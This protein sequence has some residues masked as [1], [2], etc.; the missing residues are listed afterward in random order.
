MK[1]GRHTEILLILGMLFALVAS[2]LPVLYTV[3]YHEFTNIPQAKGGSI[4]LSD[5]SGND[6]IVLDGEWEFYWN[7]FLVTNPQE[8]A[9]PDFL[10]HVPDYWSK[11]KIHGDYLPADGFASYR[12]LLKGGSSAPVTIYLP[13]FGS[14]YRVFIDGILTAQS[15]NV[16]ED[17]AEVFTTTKA[18]L[19]P[20][21]LTTQQK[22]EVIIEV[23]TT[24]F[25]GLY[26]A[27]VM[28]DYNQAVHS[29]TIR[30]DLR[31]LLFG[32]ALFSFF[33]LI[34]GYILSYSTEKHSVWLS[35]I[36]LCVLLRIMLTT[37][38]F[39]FWQDK[40]FFNLS[41]EATNPLMF[42]LS[43]AFKYL[44]I[45]L[46]EELLGIDFSKKEKM[47]LLHYYTVF[48]LV[49]LI[50]P[51]GF[52]NRYLTILLPVC[53]FLI[54]IY[55]FF[56]IYRNRHQLKQYG[57]LVY[58][59]ATLAITGLIIDCYYINGNIY[60]N[61]SMALLLLF[62]AYLII[63]GLVSSIQ[64]S[65]I[66]RDLAMSS[67]SIASARAQIAMQTEYYNALSAQMHEIRAVRH[68]FHHFVNVLKR[69]CDEAKYPELKC[70]LSE[71]A[72]KADT[73]PLP[74]FCENVV[75]NSI[76]GYYSLRL[77]EH[78]IPFHCMCHIPKELSV[79]DSDLCI[80]LGN[81]LENAME[82]C[83]KVAASDARSVLAEARMIGGQLLIKITNTYN[84]TVIAVGDTFLTTKAEP[85]HGIGMKN[86]KKVLDSY[87]GY[88]KLENNQ[89]EFTLMA[90][91]PESRSAAASS[92]DICSPV[93]SI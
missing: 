55:A 30:N 68:D 91:F 43:F 90:A 59:G 23:A 62:T 19:Y 72:G 52:Y 10:I 57:L 71:Y 78:D 76:L 9:A 80:V 39:G 12:L 3:F 83:K 42:F 41:Y 15:G 58:G 14:A 34:V 6:R 44:L 26:M 21:T 85:F 28:M 74:V 35:V 70:F 87:G 40:V 64:A 25:S 46:I 84:G 79:S 38:F 22:H 51:H 7:R 67:A 17:P 2:H 11:Y 92:A 69:L 18:S 60:L 86:M 82:A 53:A 88:V 47:W 1:R 33:V 89:K 56:K 75:A 48:Y 24:R 27:P 63:L 49:Y 50:I 4:D 13:D 32:A 29:K 65:E 8:D 37:E 93:K 31:L 36:G 16:A 66:S 81:A 20:V 73:E 61:L 54:E 45:F 5:I 77:K